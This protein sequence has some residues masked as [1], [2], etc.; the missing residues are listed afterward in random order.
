MQIIWTLY[1]LW[2]GQY[3]LRT[4]RDTASALLDVIT[5]FHFDLDSGEKYSNLPLDLK[6]AFDTVEHTILEILY[7]IGVRGCGHE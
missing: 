5:Q 7:R 1:L 4:S 3:G 6:E 2:N